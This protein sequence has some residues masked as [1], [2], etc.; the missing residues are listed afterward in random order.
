MHWLFTRCTFSVM[1]SVVRSFIGGRV[2]GGV[3]GGILPVGAVYPGIRQC[4]L[5]GVSP[6]NGMLFSSTSD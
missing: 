5:R 2:E 4:R 3:V 1:F 6:G